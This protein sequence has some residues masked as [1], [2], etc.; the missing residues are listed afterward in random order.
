MTRERIHR[1]KNGATGFVRGA[2]RVTVAAARRR[3][4]VLAEGL[5]VGVSLASA[6][7]CASA[8]SDPTVRTVELAVGL[9]PAA[10]E[11]AAAAAAC[12]LAFV[13]SREV[14]PGRSARIVLL[15][16]AHA[17]RPESAVVEVSLLSGEAGTTV[18]AAGRSLAEYGMRAPDAEGAATGCTP[19]QLTQ[20]KFGFVQYSRG[21]ATGNAIQAVRCLAE[22]LGGQTGP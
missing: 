16:D 2:G 10:G 17:A 20:A 7:G 1:E 22:A 12:N 4:A 14:E 9:G 11:V 19:C 5:V 13:S 15:A 18:K 3:A 21:L 8:G 6:A